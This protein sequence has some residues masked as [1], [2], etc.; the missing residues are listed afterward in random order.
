MD[1]FKFEKKYINEGY[2]NIV[3]IDEAGRGPL[4]GPVVAVALNWGDK[5][6]IDGVN[7]SKKISEKKRE[8]YFNQIIGKAKDIGIGIVEEKEIDKINILQATYLAM[9][10][11]IGNLKI[12]PD[13]LLIDGNKA[14]IKH[15]KQKNIIK[16]DSLSYSIAAASIIAKV[17]RDRIMLQ[18]DIIFPKYGFAKHKGY[19]TK[20]H[21]NAIYENYST[22][23]HRK[24]FN[25]IKYYLPNIKFYKDRNLLE[26]LGKQLIAVNL[27]KNNFRIIL[28]NEKYDIIYINDK[29]MIINQIDII[30]HNQIINSISKQNKANFSNDYKDLLIN[31]KLENLTNIRT[32]KVSINLDKNMKIFVQRGDVF[33]I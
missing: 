32:D 21:L 28:F 2:Q 1:L 20:F 30:Y 7:D 18:Y 26:I 12:K 25:P 9:K 14:D 13:L 10:K 8:I 4:A 24:S 23:I 15:I 17:T 3:G 11:A 19:G 16:G 6:L 33:E 27:I 31:Y 29:V 5:P 22:P